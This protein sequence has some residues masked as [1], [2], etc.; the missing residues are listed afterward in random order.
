[1]TTNTAVQA[2]LPLSDPGPGLVALGPA[3]STLL[4]ALDRLFTG[5]ADRT[6]ALTV[7]G[8]PLLP[9]AGLAGLD[10][11]RNFPH[12][13]VSAARFA[14]DQVTELAGG[15]D[16]SG[17]PVEPTGYVLPS[18]TCY[19]VFLSLAG[20]E[21]G[22]EKRVTAVG[23]CF[24][25]ES[26]YDGLRRLWGFHMREV[27]YLGTTDG[28]AAHLA[29]ARQF[30][31]DLAGRLGVDVRYEAANDPFY[32][33][34]SSRAKLTALDP[35]KYEFVTPDGTAI[36]S[37]NRH[38]TFFGDRLGITAGGAPVATSCAAF[39]LERW[40]H[41]LEHAHGSTKAALRVMH[42]AES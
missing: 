10:Y 6:G 34:D 25:N 29:R 38:R 15:A 2:A 28:A 21:L 5:L 40:V 17:Q 26:H 7:I 18:A 11:F 4:T 8:P 23:R 42:D 37:V 31:T 36:A 19:G 16:V 35:V 33:R 12:L 13:G 14:E 27:V 30:V 41:A 1:M 24:R 22:T 9:A 39:G 3:R 20:Q 32:D